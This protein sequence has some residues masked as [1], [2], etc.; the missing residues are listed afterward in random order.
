MFFI[1]TEKQ[2]DIQWFSDKKMF[3]IQGVPK[4][5]DTFQK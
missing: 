3:E 5:P 4:V 1:Y 2:Y